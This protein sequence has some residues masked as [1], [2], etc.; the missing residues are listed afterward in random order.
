MGY[1]ILHAVD[2][3]KGARAAYGSSKASTNRQDKIRS[4]EAKKDFAMQDRALAADASRQANSIAAGAQQAALDREFQSQR[5]L[6]GAGQQNAQFEQNLLAEQM[7]QESQQQHAR[8]MA[9]LQQ[10]NAQENFDYEYT[11]QQR[12]RLSKL[13]EA[14]QTVADMEASGDL[15]ADQAAYARYSIDVQAA[16]VQPM[17]MPK[18]KVADPR[19]AMQESLVPLMLP[20]E[21]GNWQPVNDGRFFLVQPDGSRDIVQPPSKIGE[22]E[23]DFRKSE[24]DF[25]REQAALEE[26]KMR[27]TMAAELVK[28]TANSERPIGIDDAL[29]QV[30]KIFGGGDGAGPAEGDTEVYNGQRYKVFATPNGQRAIVVNGRVLVKE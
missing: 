24:L 27:F 10:R 9:E 2:P 13:N 15:D 21:S 19:Q 18:R 23:L 5:M 4:L 20:D 11:A 29:A 17:P 7:Q 3:F 14:R 1:T 25:R 26:K 6:F 16:G 30:G 22:K 12:Q 28:A 8:D